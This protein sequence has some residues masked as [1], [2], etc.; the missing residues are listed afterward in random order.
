MFS[1]G[2]NWKGL[3]SN[4]VDLDGMTEEQMFADHTFDVTGFNKDN[5]TS[6]GIYAQVGLIDSEGDL[7]GEPVHLTNTVDGNKLKERM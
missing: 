1:D 2:E 6:K 7:I 4:E 5:V 3:G